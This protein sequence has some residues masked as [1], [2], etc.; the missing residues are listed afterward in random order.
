MTNQ[1]IVKAV[2]VSAFLV[3]ALSGCARDRTVYDYDRDQVEAEEAAMNSVAGT[4]RG[5]YVSS[6]DG[7]MI[8]AL[9]IDVEPDR[10]IGA[11][12]SGPVATQQAVLK[13]TVTMEGTPTKVLTFNNGAYDHSALQF[14]STATVTNRGNAEIAG[15]FQGS[16]MVGTLEADGYPTRGGSFQLTKDA[17]LPSLVLAKTRAGAED[18][19][20]FNTF[21]A[22]GNF[23]IGNSPNPEDNRVFLQVM[24]QVSVDDQN[25]MD[26]ITPYRYV[27]VGVFF[28]IKQT[29]NSYRQVGGVFSNSTWDIGAGTLMGTLNTPGGQGLAPGELKLQCT[30]TTNGWDC[31]EFNVTGGGGVLF[32]ADFTPGQ[33]GSFPMKRASRWVAALLLASAPA[34][35]AKKSGNGL[36]EE[37]PLPG[38]QPVEVSVPKSDLAPDQGIQPHSVVSITPLLEEHNGL[39]P[40]LEAM[41]SSWVPGSLKLNSQLSGASAVQGTWAP[42]VSLAFLTTPIARLGHLE[43]A[44]LG[45]L[46]FANMSRSGIFAGDEATRPRPSIRTSTCR[47]SS[48]RGGTL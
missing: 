45:G 28:N 34:L 35:A 31:Q 21:T 18:Q 29:D 48:R 39:D 30:Q 4:Y 16:N 23:T 22:I 5:S 6:V 2:G 38:S 20:L 7:S 27:D 17:A 14:K 25:L 43:L 10:Q 11:S 1:S 13:I 3:A 19:F 33:I 41:V 46:S 24:H 36:P 42:S 8:G 37:N 26:V 47:P 32:T 12:G 15:T 40:R 44:L 9:T